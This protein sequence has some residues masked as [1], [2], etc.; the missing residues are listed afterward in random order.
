MTIA[1]KDLPVF[2]INLDRSKDR[3][4]T[5]QG[6][7]D[8][9]GL[10]WVR[11]AG[12]DGRAEW[13]ILA[14]NLDITRFERNVGRRIMAGEIG[15]YMSHLA[16]WDR[17]IKSDA[18][19]GLILEDDVV[20]GDDFIPAL[21]QLMRHPPTWDIVKLNKIRAKQPVLRQ[22]LGQY[23]L[24]AYIGPFTGMG[25]YVITA[26]AARR[27]RGGMLPITRPIDHELDRIFHHRLHHYGMEPFPSYVED[28]GHST[29]TGANFVD[30]QKFKGFK[31]LPYQI[32]RLS[33]LIRKLWFVAWHQN[34]L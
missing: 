29:I 25:A 27:L 4:K 19:W 23:R 14:Q 21:E 33:N 32:L 24:N 10:P 15:C 5:M 1:L 3:L 16:A 2:L 22:P 9:L 6:R 8:H 12:I 30:V 17:L 11:I 28:Q 7:L 34:N 13:E 26:Q 18:P 31:R 20:F